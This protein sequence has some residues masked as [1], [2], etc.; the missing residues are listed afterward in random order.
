MRLFILYLSI[1]FLFFECAK[2]TRFYLF[3][4]EFSKRSLAKRTLPTRSFSYHIHNRDSEIIELSSPEDLPTRWN[5]LHYTIKNKGWCI[6]DL[7][8]SN[9]ETLINISRFLGQRQRCFSSDEEGITNIVTESLDNGTAQIVSKYFFSPHTD[10]HYLN[11]MAFYKNTLRRIIPPKFMLLQ[12]VQPA[13]KGGE[14][15]LI[16]GRRI[17]I[18]LIENSSEIV[19][20]LFSRCMNIHH[21]ETIASDLPVFSSVSP[22]TYSIR[23]SYDKELYF[24]NK[25][26]RALDIFNYEYI[27]NINYSIKKS[28][29]PHQILVLDNKRILHGREEVFGQRFYRRVWIYDEENSESLLNANPVST[30]FYKTERPTK[31]A[32]LNFQNFNPI[33]EENYSNNAMPNGIILEEETERKLRKLLSTNKP[34]E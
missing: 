9:K 26:K 13:E 20:T 15:L 16:D 7:K 30:A 4:N 32:L 18:D 24:S 8:D 19:P 34:N 22:H 11:G 3:V 2:A 1:S 23:W 29:L 27:D 25:A 31:D 17:L 21:N 12:C 14:N 33:D 28:L 6:L 5:Q 10:G